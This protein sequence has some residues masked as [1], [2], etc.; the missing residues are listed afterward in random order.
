[1][2][3]KKKNFWKP[4]AAGFGAVYLLIMGLA[5]CLVKAKF[6]EDYTR[7]CEETAAFIVGRALEKEQVLE[8]EG[9][10]SR[11]T[12]KDFYQ[13]LANEYLWKVEDENLQV[14]I[15]FYDEDKRLLARTRDEIGGNQVTFADTQVKKYTSYGL[16]DYLSQEEKEALAKYRWEDIHFN[17]PDEPGKYRFSIR[18]SPDEKELWAIYVQEIT[19]TPEEEWDGIDHPDSLDGTIYSMEIAGL[20]DYATGEEMGE[21]RSFVQTDSR[22]VWQWMNSDAGELPEEEEIMGTSIRL[23]YMSSYETWRGY[24]SWRR[25]NRSPY[26]GDFLEQREFTWKT[27]IEEPLVTVD[28]DGFYYRG[29][30]QLQVGELGNPSSY[31]EIHMESR[32]WLAA[33]DYMKYV[34]LAGF[35]MS[36][37]CTLKIIHVFRK[38]YDAQAILEETRRDFTNAMAHELKTPLGVI[39]NFAENLMEHNMEEKRDYYLAQI[40][41]QT[42]EIDRLVVKMIEI[43][44][45]DSDELI[46]KKE[47][48]S[49]SGLV[50]EQMARFGPMVREKNI[51]AQYQEEGDF[52]VSGDREYLAGAVWNLL[53][54]AVE[55][56]IPDGRIVIKTER[57]RC[58]IENTAM[59]MAEDELLHAFDMLYTG[60]KSRSKKE[61]H[62]GMGLFLAKKILGLHGL[63]LTL[64]NTGDGVRAEIRK[65]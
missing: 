62:M 12:R 43:S 14:S 18:T 8:E 24:E 59:P 19:W 21:G 13:S 22:I 15:G 38:T 41:G 4:A 53:S 49:F 11:E 31:M 6:A 55:Y 27:G 58:V 28:S 46:L 60:D 5:T 57:D 37:V 39:R 17:R 32:P 65:T 63:G 23:P 61:G 56:N 1:M 10:E 25:W 33:M 9:W 51:Q 50:R 7:Q 34:Y 52:L 64:E 30:Y 35:V 26:L 42:E 45:L 44:R 40:I 48:V 2:R 29:M 54:N 47:E 36:L 20:I 16:D 3:R